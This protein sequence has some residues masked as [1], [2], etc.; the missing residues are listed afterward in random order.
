MFRIGTGRWQ[1]I[2]VFLKNK[3][4]VEEFRKKISKENGNKIIDL[5]IYEK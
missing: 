2:E 3:A 4:E 1:E 5:Y